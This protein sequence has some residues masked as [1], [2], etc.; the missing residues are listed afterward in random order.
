M[1]TT[2]ELPA[3]RCLP[4]P[5]WGAAA[6]T[7]SGGIAV[8]TKL[9]DT[10]PNSTGVGKRGGGEWRVEVSH[11][12]KSHRE[13]FLSS[14]RHGPP[15]WTLARGLSAHHV[16]CERIISPSR[17]LREDYQPITSLARGLSAHHV[18][19]ERTISPSRPLREDY[20]SSRPLREDY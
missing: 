17:P 1:P 15:P 18:P 9:L 7:L 10:G 4:K 3:A 8:K 6:F 5:P 13:K 2:V 11:A 19:C 14:S 20:S 16:P 12:P